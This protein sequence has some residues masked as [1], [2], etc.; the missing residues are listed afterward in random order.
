[1]TFCYQREI[2]CLKFKDSSP[3]AYQMHTCQHSLE[4][5]EML[6]HFCGSHK[7]HCSVRSQNT[8]VPNNGSKIDCEVI[9]FP[10]ETT[11]SFQFDLVDSERVGCYWRSKLK[12][13]FGGTSIVVQK[14]LSL[15]SDFSIRNF[16]HDFLAT[17]NDFQFWCLSLWIYNDIQQMNFPFMRVVCYKCIFVQIQHQNN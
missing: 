3:L 14:D 9:D 11:I 16:Y 7:V 17:S 4:V 15:T 1:M 5:P 6:Q 10:Q 8:S 12:T 13:W 2:D